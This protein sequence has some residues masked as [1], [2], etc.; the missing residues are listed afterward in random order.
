MSRSKQSVILQTCRIWF[1]HGGM[2]LFCRLFMSNV[3]KVN[4]FLDII[5]NIWTELYSSYT[6]WKKNP[7]F[8]DYVNISLWQGRWWEGINDVGGSRGNQ[9]TFCRLLYLFTYNLNRRSGTQRWT[10]SA[11]ST[12]L[13]RLPKIYIKGRSFCEIKTCKE[14]LDWWLLNKKRW[15]L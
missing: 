3:P 13:L 14:G 8:T 1:I 12:A 9:R 11:L 7:G 2:H 10:P 4:T 15:L 5:E 6:F